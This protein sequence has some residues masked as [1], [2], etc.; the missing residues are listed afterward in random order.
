MKSTMSFPKF[1]GVNIKKNGPILTLRKN[2]GADPS[3]QALEPNSYGI[4]PQL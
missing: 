4:K 1:L 2:C 3:T